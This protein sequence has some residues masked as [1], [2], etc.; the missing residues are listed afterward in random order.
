[1]KKFF[2][3]LFGVLLILLGIFYALFFTQMGNNIL[4]PT[5]ESKIAEAIQKK[6]DVETFS[7]RTDS[8]TLRLK[9]DTHSFLALDGKFNLFSKSFD[10]MFQTSLKD[11]TFEPIQI[12][13]KMVLQ[14]N[15][16]GTLDDFTLTAKGNALKGDILI[17]AKG[18]QESLHDT[19][20][21]LKQI[22]TKEL[23]ALLGKPAYAEGLFDLAMDI[24]EASKTKVEGK[25][26]FKLQATKINDALVLK[27]FNLSIPPNSMIN[28]SILTQMS[29]QK[30]ISS[31]DIASTLATLKTKQTTYT[32]ST[33]SLASDYLLFVQDFSKFEPMV[34][35]K[36][37]GEASFAGE[38][39]YSPVSYALSAT[40]NVFDGQSYLKL[41]ND[42][43]EAD[44]SRLQLSKIM[45]FLDKPSYSQGELSV[46]AKLVSL[47]NLKG[48]IVQSIDNGRVD[49]ALVNKDFNQTLPKTL[50][51]QLKSDTKIEN[52][53]ATIEAQALSSLANIFLNNAQFDIK[54][55]AFNAQYKVDVEDLEA[56]KTIA[57]REL[58]GKASVTGKIKTAE[59][60]LY[61]D[62]KSE[63]FGGAIDFVLENN[64]FQANMKEVQLSELLYALT[65]PDFFTST[66][67]A[68]VQ[69][70]TTSAKGTLK[71][72]SQDG[73]FKQN[74]LG[75]LLLATTGFDLTQE[76]YKNVLANARIEQ[77]EVFFDTSMNSQNTMITV[78]EG[79]IN[80]ATDALKS[81][82]KAVILGKEYLANISGTMSNPKVKLDTSSVVKEAVK[83]KIEKNLPENTKNL[84]KGFGF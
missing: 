73:R 7:L 75:A 68:E 57:K 18:T 32:L 83:G 41:E 60:K 82:L 53:R 63:L 33:Q 36:L 69:Y 59:Q 67:A 49:T 29:G 47:Q 2:L 43:L 66:L 17:D 56:L 48:V 55:K 39:S 15:L 84:L 27:D 1:M 11:I 20:V 65:Y 12:N 58:R 54:E 5:V 38:L 26:D 80:Q 42:T 23:L 79:Y 8:L 34:G 3:Y 13:S 22:D 77:D 25:S 81:K 71:A 40:S 76:I 4:K 50:T 45:N 35:L 9:I 10:A 62:G 61:V 44:L 19:T 52:N 64:L 14:G 51:Y 16:K 78:E 30:I 72:T 37:K 28:A 31:I 74:Q 21:V 24:K 46:K 6:V 70:D